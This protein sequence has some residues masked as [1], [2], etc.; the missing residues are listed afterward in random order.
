M[1]AVRALVA[2]GVGSHLVEQAQMRAFSDE[3]VIHRAQ[4][5]P[6]GI[7]VVNFPG[8]GRIGRRIAQGLA[9][10][11]GKTPFEQA[12][13]FAGLEPADRLSIEC[14]RLN[15]AGTGDEGAGEK[16]AKG[17]LDAENRKRVSMRSGS[18]CFCFFRR[19]VRYLVIGVW[20]GSLFGHGPAFQI[21]FAYWRMVRSEENHPTRAVL[22]IVRRYQASSSTH[23]LSTWRCAWA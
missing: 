7:G 21:S 6:V 1:H 19:K 11:D 16:S 14:Q 8:A 18:D 5:G 22:R 15:F 4:Y 20:H 10:G 23:K 12:A 3:I 9:G 2:D 13:D 17:F